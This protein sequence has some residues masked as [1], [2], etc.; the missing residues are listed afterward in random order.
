MASQLE[1]N[2]DRLIKTKERLLCC[3]EE[4]SVSQLQLV[5]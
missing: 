5:G 2:F 3:V 4:T 1:A